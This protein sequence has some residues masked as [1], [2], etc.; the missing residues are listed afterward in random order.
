MGG[1]QVGSGTPAGIPLAHFHDSLGLLEPSMG[2]E[3]ESD[4]KPGFQVHGS[5]MGDTF[6]RA[7]MSPLSGGK[8]HLEMKWLYQSH[9]PFC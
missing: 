6:H 8:G 3:V 4:A 5:E 9:G 2:V 7:R 1:S